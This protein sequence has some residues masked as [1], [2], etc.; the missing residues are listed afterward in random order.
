MLDFVARDEA[1]IHADVERMVFTNHGFAKQGRG[2]GDIEPF[3]QAS[4]V[5]LETES[6]DLGAGQGLRQGAGRPEAQ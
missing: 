6:P 2:D 5:V 1:A 4:Q 3:D